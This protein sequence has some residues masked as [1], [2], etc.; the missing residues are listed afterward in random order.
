MLVDFFD[1]EAA[2]FVSV[3]FEAD[4]FAAGFLL[5][6][7]LV[8][9]F[10]VVFFVVT[11]FEE[12]DFFVVFFFD[13]PAADFVLEAFEDDFLELV[14]FFLDVDAFLA[15]AYLSQWSAPGSLVSAEQSPE[16][17]KPD[18]VGQG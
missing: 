9:V 13:P 11:F 14:V 18:A 6:A 4:F 5:A 12:A 1:F 15:T 3:F 16:T 8:V 17:S 7:F 2:F 10:F